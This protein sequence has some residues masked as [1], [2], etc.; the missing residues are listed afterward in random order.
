MSSIDNRTVEMKFDNAQFQRGVSD[1]TKSLE[2]LK[3]G[4]NLDAA[5]KS[6]TELNAAGSRFSLANIGQSVQG[7]GQQFSAMGVVAITTLANITT[8]ALNTGTAMAKSLTL[9]P[10]MEG[11]NE[12]ELKMG[13]IQ[14]ILSNTSRHGTTLEDVKHNLEELNHYA[15]QTIYNF[16][17][18]T[19][20]IGYFTNAGIKLEDATAMIK[21]FSNEAASSGTN[22]AQ[23]AGAAYQLSQ[24]L[25]KGK[26]T[27]EDWRS[28]TNASMGN[29]NM[30]TG[31]IDIA[32]AMGTFQT[33]GTSAE[34]V[35]K[36]FNGTLEKGWLTA[37]VMSTYL[38][39]Q[40]GEFNAE[41]MKSLG[42]TQ[43]QIDMFVKQQLTAEEAATKVRTWTQL[44]GTIRESVGSSWAETW[45]ILIGDF[46]E[47]TDLFTSVNDTLSEIIKKAS[48]A[49][50]DLLQSVV[51]QGGR[52]LAIDSIKNVF[53]TVM[54]LVKPIQEAFREIF[55]PV[56]AENIISFLTK[57]KTFT[58][59]LKPGAETLELIKRSFKGIF[60][61][62]DI[63]VAIIQGIWGLFERL[64]KSM[65]GGGTSILTITANIGDFLVKVRDGIRSGEGL[66][67]FFQKLGDILEPVVRFLKD[68]VR[69]ISEAF[70]GFEKFGESVQGNIKGAADTVQRQL[71]PLQKFGEWLRSI[72]DKVAE[73][74][75]RVREA[76]KPLG[77][78]LRGVGEAF[79]RAMSGITFDGVLATLNTG[80]LA[81]IFLMIK[82]F[83]KNFKD[84]FDGEGIGIIDSIKEVFGGLTDSLSAMQATLKAHTLV[85]IA[86][87][88]ALL[89]ASVVALTL[90]D[91]NKLAAA[92]AAMTVMFTQLVITLAAFEKVSIGASIGSLIGISTA[93]VI[94]AIAVRILTGAV[95]KLGNMDWK[96]LL[97]GLGG[98]ITLLAALT[99]VA[100]KMPKNPVGMVATGI[101]IIA[102]SVAIKILASAVKD[103]EELRWQ[104]VV[105][106]LI[107][108]GTIL[109]ALTLFT[110]FAAVNK[111]AV[112]QA[113]GLILLGVAIKILASAVSDF[114]QM[115]IKSMMKGLAALTVTIT[116][117]TAFSNLTKNVGGMVM[118]GT[119]LVILAAGMKILAS[120][121]KDFGSMDVKS[122]IKGLVGL[123]A[124]LGIITI[125]MLMLPPTTAIN[126]VGLVVIAAALTI[127]ADVI[128][129]LGAM[130]WEEVA[131]GLVALAGALLVIT[132]TV[133]GMTAAVPGAIALTIVCAA[134]ALLGPV[135]VMLGNMSWDNIGRGL[136]MLAA[137]LLII[138]L[139]GAL[140]TPVVP[141]LIG[142]GIAIGL[143]GLGA[144][145]A[146]VGLLAFSAGLAALAVSG[147]A[148]TAVL[149][150]MIHGL[151]G[152]IPYAME[153][154]GKGLVLF[155]QVIIEAGP[156]WTSAAVTL[157]TSLLTGINQVTPLI[158]DT[159]INLL[160][161]LIS[162]IAENTPRFAQAGSDILIGFLQG[163]GNNIGRVVDEATRIV[164]EFINGVSR[165]LPQITQAGADLIIAFVDSLASTIRSNS[166]RMRS[167][168]WDLAVAIADGMTGGMASKVGD[169]IKGA[170]DM[171]GSALNA[172]K[173]FLNINSPSRVFRDQVGAPITEGVAVGIS[174]NASMV[175]EAAEDV[176][177]S[178]LTGLKKSI[179]KVK[180]TLN[181]DMDTSMTIRPVMDLTQIRKDANEVN[182]MIG[183]K[184]EFTPIGSLNKATDISN[185]RAAQEA[186]SAKEEAETSSEVVS[187][188]YEQNIYSPKAVGAVEA[189][190]G[191]KNQLSQLKNKDKGGITSRAK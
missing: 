11:F 160:W 87:A 140:L 111:G 95:E 156:V 181:E 138:G 86:I 150:A 117:L 35:A 10:I 158:I 105:K 122:L 166:E 60:A 32:K 83:F 143:L 97:K 153:Q 149:I 177:E 18:M 114:A 16:G 182:N 65:D 82:G 59:G 85:A 58:E 168:G 49:R 14:T 128:K 78:F 157:L 89:V 104:E 130:S 172:A 57:I 188:N 80:L 144:A 29:K 190:R 101:G 136:T 124:A 169:L 70:N 68:V 133:A 31:L 13:S 173:D 141:S 74:F 72:W 19:R 33:A 148:G 131:R 9:D 44:I 23:A 4:L 53:D 52:A 43:Q 15:D 34:A 92:L 139:A 66:N 38:R 145:L 12:Y 167:A 154:F 159:L 94:L 115:D 98:V 42:L 71:S 37:D 112:A 187:I 183:R 67:K 110:K 178:A 28:L 27:L 170:Q 174:K 21:G 118:T 1:T 90:I 40:A 137:S 61:V 3:K 184:A 127:L 73:A 102:L 135:L 26:I 161:K 100:N 129:K 107:G 176:G 41:Q 125:A 165:N 46:N 6:L 180:S 47:A 2:G 152:L 62:L 134:L 96:A 171:V 7:V 77:D 146:G 162:T 106:G 69:N 164:V 103:F 109:G 64:F 48:N 142:L 99:V 24:A 81:G 163:I 56:T 108:V 50:N 155:A 76:F 30:Q 123:G 8:A 179:S 116:L 119:G 189:Y 175:S 120:A 22:A 84:L 55:P 5:S 75:T 63:G 39:I 191:T 25:S 132:L 45:E 151:L 36:D 51:T 20:N 93:M 121:V 79:S 185:E 126:A 88:L 113:T 17:D 54:A 147:A 186:E 91:Q